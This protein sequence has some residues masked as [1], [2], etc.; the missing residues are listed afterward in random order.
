METKELVKEV[1]LMRM[2][3]SVIKCFKENFDLVEGNEYTIKILKK[4]NGFK[5]SSPNKTMMYTFKVLEIEE[6]IQH[7]YDGLKGKYSVCF[8]INGH[9]RS[10]KS[11]FWIHSPKTIE[12]IEDALTYNIQYWRRFDVCFM[13]KFNK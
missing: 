8:S 3:E 11:N 6:K 1:E 12:P 2:S 4:G 9:R 5:I 7:G 13:D 10:Y